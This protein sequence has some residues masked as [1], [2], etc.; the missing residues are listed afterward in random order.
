MLRLGIRPGHA[1]AVA[2]DGV[3]QR[4]VRAASLQQFPDLDAMRVGPLFKIQ[5]VKQ[6]DLTPK[7]RLF[8]IAQ[9]IGKPAHYGLDRQGVAEMKRLLVVFLQQVPGL[10]VGKLHEN[11]LL[12][13][14][15]VS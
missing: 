6:A 11:R 3:D 13:F 7:L 10:L 5:V 15:F 2:D 12:C 14:R 9:R 4:G 1:P 8:S